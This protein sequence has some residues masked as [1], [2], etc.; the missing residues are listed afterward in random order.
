M[1]PPLPVALSTLWNV[2]ISGSCSAPRRIMTAWMQACMHAHTQCIFSP[3]TQWVL[4]TQVGVMGWREGE[5]NHGNFGTVKDLSLSVTIVFS[6]RGRGRERGPLRYEWWQMEQRK[7]HPVWKSKHFG[8]EEWKDAL[9]IALWKDW[10]RYR[11][12]KSHERD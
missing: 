6:Y 5:P 2:L 3:F 7:K 10:K 8:R 11:M 1:L 9:V 12:C 4:V